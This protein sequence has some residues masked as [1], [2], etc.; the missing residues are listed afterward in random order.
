MKVIFIED[1]KL[2][3]YHNNICSKVSKKELDD[4]PICN[5]KVPEI[6]IISYGGE[7]TSFHENIVPKVDFNQFF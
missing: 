5:T 6:K 2:F 3:K 7:S 1:D 4:K